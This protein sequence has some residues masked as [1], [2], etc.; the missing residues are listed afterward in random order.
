MSKKAFL[1]ILDGWGIGNKSESDIIYNTPTPNIDAIVAKAANSKLFAHGENV[2][3]PNGQMGNSEVGHLNIGAGRVIFQDLVK[4][5]NA[6]KDNSIM[7]N[8]EIV[9]AYTYA[10]ENNKQIHLLGLVSEG[11]VHSSLDHLCKLSE[12]SKEFGV[13]KTFVHCFMDGRDTDPKSGKEYVQKLQN[14]LDAN[15]GEIATVIGRFYAMDR[16]KR[17]E[18]V[19]KSYDLMVKGAGTPSTNVIESIQ[20]SYDNNVTD[21]FIEPIVAV[22]A[23][24]KPK[25]LI[26]KD[27]VVIF[28]NFRNDRAKELSICFTQQDML[29]I[30]R[31]ASGM[32]PEAQKAINEMENIPLYYCTMTPYDDKYKGV[33]VLFDKNNVEETLGEVVSKAGLT[34]LRIAETEKYPHVTFFFNGGREDAFEGENRY[35]VPSPKVATY[36]LQPEMSAFG[37]AEGVIKEMQTN[38]PN[39][40]I[41]N[42]AN[43]DMVGH[44]GIVDAIQKAVKTVDQCVGDVMK[45]AKEKGYDVMII[46]DHGNAD[47][48]FNEDGSPNTAHTT[49]PVPCIL[50]SDTYKEVKDGILADVAP[51]LLKLMGLEQPAAMSGKSLV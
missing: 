26:E 23:N 31:K 4:I 3:L 51:T 40:I 1:M 34:Q 37:V 7:Q 12:V 13:N 15:S 46:A 29:E 25:G 28:F 32:T 16:D 24:G 35:L 41:L 42:F 50:V 27:D 10:K 45:V 19:Q 14:A 8:D 20:T 22:D 33:H 9:K 21:E 11:G 48:A 44:T 38:E 18:R 17:W 36:D 30:E 47:F 43:G 39:L 6:C 5:N 49:N 2:G